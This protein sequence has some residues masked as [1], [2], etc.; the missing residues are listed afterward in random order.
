MDIDYISI[1]RLGVF[2]TCNYKYKLQ[3]HDHIKSPLP[4]PKFF[5]YGSL[6][7]KYAELTVKGEPFNGV[8]SE[9]YA[10]VFPKHIENINKLIASLGKEGLTEH[11]F[12]LDYKGA[13]IKGVIDR[14]LLTPDGYRI[15]D[16]KS[17][18]AGS[19]RKTQDNISIDPQLNTYAWAV[20][21]E[22]EVPV[23]TIKAALYYVD[24]GTLITTS[25]TSEGVEKVME[26]LKYNYFKIKGMKP[27]DAE[28]NLKSCKWCNYRDGCAK[29]DERL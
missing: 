27:E 5:K 11:T 8:P 3:Y 18:K 23:E 17:T 15:V 2:D 10:L 12:L 7:H 13:A 22:F 21:E 20:S 25:F 4:E 9:D 28:G 16:Y 24:D 6:I 19:W 14:L 26:N 1:S 29:R